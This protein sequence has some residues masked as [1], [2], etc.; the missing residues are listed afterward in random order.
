M[1]RTFWEERWKQR[2]IGFHEGRPGAMLERHVSRIG[3]CRRV[4]VPL[5]GKAMDVGFLRSRGHVVFGSELVRAPIVELFEELD[6]PRNETVVAPFQKHVGRDL[7]VLEGDAFGVT[8]DHFGGEIDAIYD[9]AALVA[10][11]PKTRRAYVETL[12]QVLR[13]AGLLLLVTF[14]YPQERIPGPPWAVP[15]ADVH[16]LFGAGFD[17]EL[18][19]ESASTGSPKF[20]A[21]GVTQLT[22]RGFLMKR[23]P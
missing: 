23:K 9:R 2:Q 7:T 13:P 16:A 8:A 1:E 12:R 6:E 15:T 5:C 14:D 3:E 22:E 21:A 18:L 20:A 4:Y 19:E 17:I 10:L 11:D